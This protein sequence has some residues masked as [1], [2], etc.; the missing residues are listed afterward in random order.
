MSRDI[1]LH[2][3]SRF[4]MG[5][6]PGEAESIARDPR[7]W[8]LAQLEQAARPPEL[9]GL[10]GHAETLRREAELRRMRKQDPNVGKDEL[11]RLYVAEAGART[12]AAIASATPVFE[13]LVRFWS[14][15]FTVSAARPEVAPIAGAFEREAIRPNILGR[16]HDLLTAVVHHPAMLLYLDNAQSIGP[17]SPAGRRNGKGLNEN[18]ARELLELHTLGVD[19]GYAQADVEGLA[20]IL[21]GWT[22]DPRDGVFRFT[23]NRHQP[24]AKTVLGR[25]FEE[26]GEQEAGRALLLLSR[27]PATARFL[28]TKLARHFVADDPPPALVE[29]L[30]RTFLDTDGD[31]GAV[32]RLLV[33]R[34]ESWN[35]PLAKLRSPDDLVI[36]ALRALGEEN[37][38]T[39]ERDR[40]LVQ[41]LTLLGQA[42]WS[43]PSPAGRPDRAE[44]WAG[45]EAMMRRLEWAKAL[46]DRRRRGALPPLDQFIPA[47][48]ATRRAL[49][50]AT[51]AEALFL[52][53][54]SPEF[55]RR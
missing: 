30:A 3:L 13:R 23:P 42:P 26:E 44:D 5:A 14:N 37:G 40:R 27:H 22:V 17:A 34:S 31:L 4:G 8:V 24:G 32:T 18:L 39:E 36:A 19:G 48:P 47:G 15:H 45:P 46:A 21:T 51:G 25:S 7:A 53:L 9:A 10:P 41:S 54:A 50:G 6:A 12:R 33:T 20:R 43:A 35:R 29:A 1:A 52:A 55:Q 11:R 2:A 49:D 28:A 16:F 38:T